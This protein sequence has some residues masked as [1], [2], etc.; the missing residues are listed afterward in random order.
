MTM[1]GPRAFDQVS[2]PDGSDEMVVDLYRM[3]GREGSA[4]PDPMARFE[5]VPPRPPIPTPV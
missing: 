3:L 1:D 2:V 4:K 5:K